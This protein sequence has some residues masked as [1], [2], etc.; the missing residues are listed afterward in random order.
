M[1]NKDLFYQQLRGLAIIAVVLIHSFSA[2]NIADM[3]LRQFINFAVPVFIFLSG[4][5]AKPLAET[6]FEF[7]KKRL[8]RIII[9]YFFWSIVS[10]IFIDK[11]YGF[12]ISKILNSFILGKGM[13][14]IFYFI[15][16]LIQLILLTPFIFKFKDNKIISGIMWLITPISLTFLY[17][18]IF[19]MNL[20]LDWTTFSLPFTNLFLFYYY[21]IKLR[22]NKNFEFKIMNNLKFNSALL[23]LSIVLS[24][25]EAL[26]M[27]KDLNLYSFAITQAKISSI[28]MSFCF[29][30]VA[31]GLKKYFNKGNFLI[32]IG[33]YSFG[34]Y[35]MHI[36]IMKFTYQINKLPF[37]IFINQTLVALST[38]I[39]CLIIIK[40]LK[41]FS[42]KS[43][44]SNVLGF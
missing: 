13:G 31:I 28:L 16:V 17:V 14:G 19:G 27:Y 20:K 40:T 3:A 6:K 41:R 22:S 37:N 24:F 42:K 44:T 4:Y 29:I 11:F 5:F 10:I 12:S 21:G 32:L 8:K 23:V 33:D 7:Y 9:P 36:L 1:E 18:L 30:N 34:I 43:F 38:L 35:L 39:I 25:Y 2:Q 15:I 26:T